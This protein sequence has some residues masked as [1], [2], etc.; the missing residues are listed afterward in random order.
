M[1]GAVV[2]GARA[3]A[4]P[5][6]GGGRK[7]KIGPG[8]GFGE[9]AAAGA[10]GVA[11]DAEPD[12]W[13]DMRLCEVRIVGWSSQRDAESS[14]ATN[15][16]SDAPEGTS[17]CSTGPPP[18]YL[19]LDAGQKV[20][21]CALGF[22]LNRSQADPRDV[23]LF[24]SDP[25]DNPFPELNW[26]LVRR[27][28]VPGGPKMRK[29]Q[30]QLDFRGEGY[31]ARYWKLL[32]HGNWGAHWGVRLRGPLQVWART[33]DEEQLR[34]YNGLRSLGTEMAE[35][36]KQMVHFFDEHHNLT[37]QERET[38]SL[39]RRHQ[40]PLVEAEEIMAQFNRFDTDQSGKL[41]WPE[42]KELMRGLLR[43][44]GAGE[45]ISEHRYLHFWRELDAD[46]S[47]NVSFEE[48][49]IWYHRLFY[50]DPKQ[51]WHNRKVTMTP[52]ERFY[53]HHGEN[54][55]GPALRER[56]RVNDEWAKMAEKA[57]LKSESFRARM[58]RR[59]EEA[60]KYFDYRRGSIMPR[61]EEGQKRV[62]ISGSESQGA[63]PGGGVVPRGRASLTPRK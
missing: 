14:A 40:V 15:L 3:T 54:R 42:F 45:D 44:P 37:E 32:I 41:E 8:G 60:M 13:N 11:A 28:H 22:L 48:F 33:P 16:D 2:F 63:R 57:A 29:E 7:P 49:L 61:D 12:V 27:F 10:A 51:S 4:T 47:E 35:R 24:A 31:R 55:L 30:A 59:A 52:V 5:V 25:L 21:L 36:L 53:A 1:K 56:D 46:R 43:A 18:Q 38:R 9:E 58:K 6:G 20:E 34:V 39:A 23:A 26:S 19:I 62:R 50:S 17:W